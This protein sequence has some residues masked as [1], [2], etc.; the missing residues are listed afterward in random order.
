MR[1]SERGGTLKEIFFTELSLLLRICRWMKL[2][3]MND[4]EK[5]K[6]DDILVGFIVGDRKILKITVPA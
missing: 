5:N 3:R 2:M 4:P 1:M 6:A